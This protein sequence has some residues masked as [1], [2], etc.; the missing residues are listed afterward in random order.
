MNIDA[1]THL[2]PPNHSPLTNENYLKALPTY[3]RLCYTPTK[4]NHTIQGWASCEQMID[5]MDQQGIH[6]VVTLGNDPEYQKECLNKYP[7]R[8]ICFYRVDSDAVLTNP[9]RE[10][11]K[12]RH[13]ILQEGFS[14]IGEFHP[15]IAGND[16]YS[17]VI[18]EVMDLAQELNVPVNIHVSEPVGHFYYGKSQNGLDEYYWLAQH[19]PD[20]KIILAH[21][22]GGLCFYEAIPEVRKVLKNVYYDTAGS[23]L[24]FDVKKSI[25]QITQIVDPS[26]IFYG[27]DYPLLLHPDEHPDVNDPRFIWD[28]ND[29]LQANV[30]AKVL[31]GIMGDNFA[32]FIDILD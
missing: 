5:V 17:P 7:G 29:F 21:W 30:P 6:K 14:G 10:F 16:L 27:S 12:I 25:E 15:D 9:K 4:F 1:H 3:R 19:F 32:Q 23:K 13:Y 22:G 31:D 20:L 24:F 18:L 8:I 26:K 11:Q 28:R 2:N